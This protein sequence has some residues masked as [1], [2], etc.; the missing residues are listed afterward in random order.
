MGKT[1]M[2]RPEQAPGKSSQTCTC[3]IMWKHSIFLIIISIQ[4]YKSIIFS[5]WRTV[6]E[7]SYLSSEQPPIFLSLSEP[8]ESAG[9]FGIRYPLSNLNLKE[10]DCS[11]IPLLQGISFQGKIFLLRC[12][13]LLY[14]ILLI[15][16]QNL[17]FSPSLQEPFFFPWQIFPW[18]QVWPH[19]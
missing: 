11:R 8:L 5:F 13:E 10:E 9:V 17:W 18:S 2:I 14:S 6:S 3:Q 16:S 1:Q 12:S 7:V 19:R 4:W 15:P